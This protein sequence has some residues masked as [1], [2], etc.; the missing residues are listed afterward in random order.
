[1]TEEIPRVPDGYSGATPYLV[2]RGAG[3]AIEW[4]KQVF[5]AE[6]LVRLASPDDG[7]IGHA[8]LKI[9]G[10]IVMLADEVPDMDIKAPPTIGGSS[11]G[12]MIYVQDVNTVFNDAL[13]AGASLFK[14]L[15]D[16]FYGDRSGTIDD[17]F[18][19]RWTIAS[20]IESVDNAE[21][22]RRFD[23]LFGEQ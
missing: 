8:E 18:G 11:V 23:E 1:M 16:Q 21:V 6:E 12:L 19:H 2:I 9:A 3:E 15:C 20:R 14:P 4:Y 17:P 7:S 13:E 22:K 5:R 10:G